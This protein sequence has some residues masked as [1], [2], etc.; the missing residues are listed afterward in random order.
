MTTESIKR[1]A[2]KSEYNRP[3]NKINTVN[4]IN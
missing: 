1:Q 3:R 2:G 4:V